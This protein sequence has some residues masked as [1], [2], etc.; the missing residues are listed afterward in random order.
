MVY[1]LAYFLLQEKP[2]ETLES[3]KHLSTNAVE[4]KIRQQEVINLNT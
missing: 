1:W 2:Q 4:V 3:P